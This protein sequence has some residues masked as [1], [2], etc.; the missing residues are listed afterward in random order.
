VTISPPDKRTVLIVDD[1]TASREALAHLLRT[2]G[3]RSSQA[4]NGLQAL[5]QLEAA[6][7][8][9]EIILLDLDMPVMNGRAFLSR[10]AYLQCIARPI[11]IIITGQ[12][13]RGIPGAAAVLR[14]PVSISQL[15]GLM[16]DLT[17]SQNSVTG[18][19]H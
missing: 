11:V 16:Q 2:Q 4:E 13:P 8:P 12:D 7:S 19:S 14:K 5:E 9:P 10:L 17:R 6:I 15:L 18:I 1:D 3:Y